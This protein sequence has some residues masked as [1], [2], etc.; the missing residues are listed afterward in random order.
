MPYDKQQITPMV[1]TLAAARASAAAPNASARHE[2]LV[3]WNFLNEARTWFL[4]SEK[5]SG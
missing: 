3:I 1:E 2:S 4:E 5:F